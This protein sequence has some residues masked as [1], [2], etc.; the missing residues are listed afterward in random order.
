MVMEGAMGLRGFCCFVFKM[1]KITVCVYAD[2]NCPVGRGK[3]MMK[4]KG[5]IRYSKGGGI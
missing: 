1:G 2:G 5:E 3:L 4:E